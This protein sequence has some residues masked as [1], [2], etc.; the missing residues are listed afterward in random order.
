MRPFFFFLSATIATLLFSYDPCNNLGCYENP[1]AGHFRIVSAS[2]GQ[3]LVFGPNKI[4]D[5]NKIKFYSLK[6][7]DTT[8]FNYQ[9]IKS[10]GAGYDSI[11][12]VRFFPN[13]EV[14]YMRLSNGDIDT[15]N[16]TYKTNKTKCCGTQ[17]SIM[18]FRYNNSFDISG[19][20]G[21]QELKK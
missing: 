2:T 5:K 3:D 19:L 9:P 20:T 13:P 6:G 15:L 17:T 11:L 18:N 12:L 21:I 16:I 8:F 7:T 4:Y 14:A 10:G 1:Q